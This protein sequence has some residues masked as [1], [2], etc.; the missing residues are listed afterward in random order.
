[1]T[2][3]AG[4]H[5]T[6]SFWLHI[7]TAEATQVTAFDTLTAQVNSTTL[8]TWSNLNAAAGYTQ[9]S[10]DLSS[11]AGQTVTVKFTGAED[12]SLQTSFVVDDTSLTTS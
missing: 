7:D 8:F 12:L 1:M 11:F 3:L 5:A 6:L 9:R 4:C 10:F 2:I